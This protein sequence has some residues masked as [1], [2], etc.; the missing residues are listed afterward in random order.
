V[1]PYDRLSSHLTDPRSALQ[2]EE[3]Q[4]LHEAVKMLDCACGIIEVDGRKNV[5][6]ILG[7]AAGS[8]LVNTMIGVMATAIVA[9]AK[10]FATGNV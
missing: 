3:K 8:S 6:T 2:E 4:T 10:F 9:V 5:T 1:L 7:F